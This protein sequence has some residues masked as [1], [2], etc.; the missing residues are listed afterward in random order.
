MSSEHYFLDWIFLKDLTQ[1]QSKQEIT[2]CE[3]IEDTLD[4]IKQ[5]MGN[6]YPPTS[7]WIDSDYDEVHDW[8]GGNNYCYKCAEFVVDELLDWLSGAVYMVNDCWYESDTSRYCSTCEKV[9]SYSL[10]KHGVKYELDHYESIDNIDLNSPEECFQLIE[11]FDR[12]NDYPEC[13]N[14]IV[15]LAIKLNISKKLI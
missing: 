4:I 7:W 2:M 9:L 11:I 14:R 6:Y 13:D 12:Y 15:A 10:T 1:I 8:F 5:K 3:I